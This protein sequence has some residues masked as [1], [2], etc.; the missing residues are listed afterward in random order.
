M[1][2]GQAYKQGVHYV[3][4]TRALRYICAKRPAQA[5]FC[6]QTALVD[7]AHGADEKAQRR[8]LAA[9][10]ILF[11]AL[12]LH[13]HLSGQMQLSSSSDPQLLPDAQ[14]VLGLMFGSAAVEQE[15]DT[16]KPELPVSGHS[17]ADPCADSSQEDTFLSPSWPVPPCM[18]FAWQSLAQQALK[19]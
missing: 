8:S 12:A 5:S 3:A 4:S 14:L 17:D 7:A 2:G 9:L 19:R 1:P 10:R 15:E 16:T 11:D 18:S 13:V 6:A